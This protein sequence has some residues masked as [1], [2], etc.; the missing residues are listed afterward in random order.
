MNLFNKIKNVINRIFYNSKRL[1][2]MNGIENA[3]TTSK[4]SVIDTSSLDINRVLTD[5]EKQKVEA[6]SQE[7]DLTSNQI[8]EYGN[9]ISRKV[10]YYMEISRKRLNQNIEKNKEFLKEATPRNVISQK[11][12]IEF[13]NLE[14]RSILEELQNLK[15]ECE[16]RIIALEEKGQA[17]IQKGK[18]LIFFLESKVDLVKVNL[19]NNAIERTK[20]TIKIIG[21]LSSSIKNELV[22]VTQEE[23]SLNRYIENSDSEENIKITNELLDKRFKEQKGILQAIQ[24]I[25][26]SEEEFP[27][28]LLKEKLGD[29]EIS[30]KLKIIVEAKRYI[31]LYVEKNKRDFLKPGGLFEK[32]QN[33]LN[34]MWEGI[35]TDY[36][37]L[38]L[39]AK[40]EFSSNYMSSKFDEPMQNIEKIINIFDEEIPEEFKRKF[41]KIKLYE[42]A[43]LTEEIEVYQ[44]FLIENETERKYYAEFLKEIIDKIHRESDDAELLQFMDKNLQLKDIDNILDDYEKITAILRIEK[45]GRKGLF[46][47]RLFSSRHFISEDLR[48]TFNSN[49]TSD[50]FAVVIL[51]SPLKVPLI[52]LQDVSE[53]NGIIDIGYKGFSVENIFENQLERNGASS[54]FALEI[55]KFWDTIP[56]KTSSFYKFMNCKS[57]SELPTR[58]V[59]PDIFD[60]IEF[61]KTIPREIKS[62]TYSGYCMTTNYNS[63]DNKTDFRQYNKLTNFHADTEQTINKKIRLEKDKPEKERKWKTK[64]I[65][66]S[67]GHGY[68][69]EES[70][71]SI[72][73][74]ICRFSIAL[75][76][77]FN[78]K[79]KREDIR[80]KILQADNF[81][82]GQGNQIYSYF[83]LMKELAKCLF[84]FKDKKIIKTVRKYITDENE[85]NDF[86]DKLFEI[87]ANYIIQ[88]ESKFEFNLPEFSE[89]SG[90][91]KLEVLKKRGLK[92]K[93]TDFAILLR[94]FDIRLKGGY[95][96]SYITSSIDYFYYGKNFHYYVKKAYSNYYER[97][98]MGPSRYSSPPNDGLVFPNAICNVRPLL[99]FSS[100]MDVPTNG[101]KINRMSDGI[102][103]VEYGYYPQNAV[104]EKL[105]AELEYA[106]KND[107]L[108]KTGNSY[109]IYV[110]T[111]ELLKKKFYELDKKIYNP[112]EYE[113]CMQEYYTQID[114]A[115]EKMITKKLDEYEYNGKKYV[116]VIVPYG[117]HET[118]WFEVLP[119]KWLIDEQDK[120]MIAD[121]VI[122]SGVPFDTRK[123]HDYKET[124]IKRFID[125]HFTKNL[126]QSNEVVLLGEHILYSFLTQKEKKVE[127][128]KGNEYEFI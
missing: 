70:E 69:F 65:K 83:E 50:S 51:Y 82:I 30:E 86:E 53:L 20:T 24:E 14:I 93:L 27:Q 5:E 106:Y 67:F 4:I 57:T 64:H 68:E 85:L 113:K 127:Q 59:I 18:K 40:R 75:E 120:V 11:L 117:N 105:M 124:A 109:D 9:E 49:A 73:E 58:V 114:E 33:A 6:Y 115:M 2:A 71:I 72:A 41:Y 19:I 1:N 25:G 100:I 39:W 46:T 76:N 123:G 119:V 37:D 101:G 126:E 125:N 111:D 16:L 84:C 35:E 99:H 52:S 122:I 12:D 44:N 110:Q 116:K 102:L 89:C 94:S 112:V 17:E 104:S 38:E 88:N 60:E 91:K 96:D 34:V 81:N 62:L 3:P 79:I 21:M 31:D 108:K 32:T 43:L 55:L 47:L 29:R 61:V 28:S 97:V 77:M 74:A 90:D 103:E 8:I 98:N 15:R 45:Y 78:G 36:Y 13:N 95:D 10:S 22:A 26:K 107:D 56:K 42:K 23:K 66:I 48:K 7:I 63:K 92:T 118:K 87:I 121:K 80:D 128:S 54:R